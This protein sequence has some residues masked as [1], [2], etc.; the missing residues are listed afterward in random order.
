MSC[1]HR[2]QCKMYV[3]HNAGF[4]RLPLHWALIN[5]TVFGRGQRE[6][7]GTGFEWVRQGQDLPSKCH[8]TFPCHVNTSDKVL[9]AISHRERVA[10]REWCPRSFVIVY[11]RC[12]FD[13]V[14]KLIFIL[15]WQFTFTMILIQSNTMTM[16]VMSSGHHSVNQCQFWFYVL[17]SICRCNMTCDMFTLSHVTCQ[18]RT[19]FC[20]IR[21]VQIF[22][23]SHQSQRHTHN[24]P[25]EIWHVPCHAINTILYDYDMTYNYDVRHTFNNDIHWT[26][27]QHIYI[28]NS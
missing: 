22:L 2:L 23:L 17:Q 16:N 20:W 25:H 5:V 1:H 9:C 13:G 4:V 27:I 10:E 7:E 11:V 14:I 6:N 26:Y 21:L 15:Q 19:M 3:W 18:E 8:V 24:D 12:Q 28:F